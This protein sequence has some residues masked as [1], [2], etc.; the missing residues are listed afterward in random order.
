MNSSDDND[1]WL[2]FI[3]TVGN[4]HSV[5]VKMIINNCN[6][7][8]QIDSGTDVNTLCQHYVKK[9]QVLETNKTLRKWNKTNVDPLGETELTVKNPRMATP[10]V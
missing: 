1:H 5:T 8:M 2:A 10:R 7:T 3:S 9:F 4:N 6:V